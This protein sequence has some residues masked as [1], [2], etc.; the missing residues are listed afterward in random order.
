MEFPEDIR[1]II[2]EFSRPYFKQF[3]EYK[4]ALR[5]HKLTS[6]PSLK[7]ALMTNA[8]EVLGALTKYEK[9]KL[10]ADQYEIAHNL[11]F[12]SYLDNHCVEEE[13]RHQRSLESIR[14]KFD[15]ATK[16]EELHYLVKYGEPIK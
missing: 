6:W 10:E 4:R 9:A 8:E 12:Q 5:V 15:L 7:K 3:R 16:R 1:R 13:E 2:Y 14:K 11:W